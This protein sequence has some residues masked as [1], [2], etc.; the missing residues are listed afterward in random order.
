MSPWLSDLVLRSQ[1]DER[2]VALARA[3]HDRAFVAIF[4]RY[5][6]QLLGFAVHLGAGSRA[7]D[8]VQQAFLSAFAALRDQRDV[9]HLSGWLHRIVRNTSIQMV[10]RVPAESALDA[11]ALAGVSTEEQVESRLEA[12]SVLSNLSQLPERQRSAL[13]QTALAGQSRSEVALSMGLSEGAVRQLVHRARSTL[14]RAAA[15]LLPAPIVTWAARGGARVARAAPA[16]ADAALHSLGQTS[17]SLTGQWG[18]IAAGAASTGGSLLVKTGAIIA[19]TGL[20]ATGLAV[21]HS[22]HHRRT[23]EPGRPGPARLVAQTAHGPDGTGHSRVARPTGPPD[24][25]RAAAGA[26]Q[27]AA[28]APGP[29]VGRPKT[30]SSQTPVSDSAGQHSSSGSAKEDRSSSAGSSATPHRADGSSS[31]RTDGS[32]KTGSTGSAGS[33]GSDSGSTSGSTTGA[34]SGSGDATSSSG[35]TTSV[36]S[37]D[38]SPSSP[39]TGSGDSSTSSS[40]T[41]SVA[42]SA[43]S[44]TSSTGSADN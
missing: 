41:D 36:S 14:R 38:G 27:N 43:S 42:S 39:S 17:E 18:P 40:G 4:E 26:A 35:D 19:A 6:R 21:S 2:L 22:E 29:A 25:T 24:S 11:D 3:G 37:G 44:G 10:G 8:V 12:H 23:A 15:A 13:I 16:T 7:E 32:P 34:G 9:I 1:S 28:S 31:G 20:V 5:K 33:S 30:A